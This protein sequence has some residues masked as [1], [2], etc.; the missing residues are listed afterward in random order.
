MLKLEKSVVIN[1]PI[2]EVFAFMTDFENATQWMSELVECK[3]TSEGPVGMGTT[4]SAVA[5]PLGRRVESTQEVAEYEPNRKYAIRSISG[6]ATSEDAYTFESVA[7]GTKITR[8]AEAEMKGLFRLTEPLAV[9]MMGRQF[10]TNFANL[11]D[12]M[13]AGA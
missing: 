11:K 3:R 12:L 1:R 9:R 6:P 4:F 5:T 8:V 7:G 13:E 2:E 10:E